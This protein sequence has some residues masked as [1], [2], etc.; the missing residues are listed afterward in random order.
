MQTR[1]LGKHIQ[2]FAAVESLLG[3]Q[4]S[5][6]DI[7]D[8]DIDQLDHRFDIKRDPEEAKQRADKIRWI[9]SPEVAEIDGV[10]MHLTI[11]QF[12]KA[13]DLVLP[14]W[15]E[16]RRHS[17]LPRQ[18]VK[19]A[20]KMAMYAD[21]LEA[22]TIVSAV[23]PLLLSVKSESI[24]AKVFA[25]VDMGSVSASSAIAIQRLDGT[26]SYVE[27]NKL[28]YRILDVYNGPVL[29][30]RIEERPGY[31]GIADMGSSEPIEPADGMAY[32]CKFS[33]HMQ[34]LCVPSPS[35]AG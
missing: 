4:F 7:P 35:E 32:D 14:T 30:A 34:T 3:Q 28:P 20:N 10:P 16:M 1:G 15:I 11:E 22:K 6:I 8:I 24:P 31:V 18:K 9:L 2:N 12:E 21:L 26:I 29:A 27:P 19:D 33:M 13:L 17:L 5:P 25:S 23:E